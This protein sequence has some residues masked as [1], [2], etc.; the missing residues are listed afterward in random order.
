[1]ESILSEFIAVIANLQ[2]LKRRHAA[3]KKEI[4]IAMPEGDEIENDHGVFRVVVRKIES[5]RL[6]TK[7]VRE[8]MGE[9]IAELE[10]TSVSTRLA[11]TFVPV[12]MDAR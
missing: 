2:E 1:M 9:D 8:I 4:L 7:R 12:I 6:D 10:T 3:M 5:K 11:V